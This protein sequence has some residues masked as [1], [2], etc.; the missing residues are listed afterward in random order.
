MFQPNATTR[1]TLKNLALSVVLI[2]LSTA[3]YFVLPLGLLGEPAGTLGFIA[4]FA[5][6]LLAVAIL[7]VRQVR[8]Y[9]GGF[10]LVGVAVALALTVLFFSS[11]YYGL[12]LH[13][14]SAF[15]SLRTK[16]D[17]LYFTLTLTSTVGFGDVHAVSQ[18]ARAVVTVNMAFNLG[19]LG[20]A[21][22][23]VRASSSRRRS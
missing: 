23:V 9:Q 14:D 2:A 12:A 10:S 21:I 20:A 17:A 16:I 8:R 1:V 5:I 15:T 11:V 18:L 3:V 13:T 22:S 7:V 6:G 4:V 19:F